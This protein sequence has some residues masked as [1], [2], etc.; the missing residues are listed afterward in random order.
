MSQKPPSGTGTGVS[1]NLKAKNREIYREARSAGTNVVQWKRRRQAGG[2]D[3]YGPGEA[4][5]PEGST[6]SVGSLLI[7]K[8]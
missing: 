2:W 6:R 7:P 1:R 4:A 5:Q 8:A 3:T